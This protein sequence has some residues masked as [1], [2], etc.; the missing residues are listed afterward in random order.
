MKHLSICEN[1][2]REAMLLFWLFFKQINKRS[3]VQWATIKMEI[4]MS[5]ILCHGDC[6]R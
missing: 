3:A 6:L 2:V 5:K 1:N 4:E